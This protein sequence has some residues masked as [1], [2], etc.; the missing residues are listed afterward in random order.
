MPPSRSPFLPAPLLL[1]LS[2]LAFAPMT[3]AQALAPQLRLSEADIDRAG[4]AVTA[5]LATLAGT[6]GNGARFAG[7]VI[8]APASQRI[9][10]SELAGVVQAL[11]VS[12]LQQVQAG[13]PMVTLFSQPYL[14]L[15]GQYVH[16]ATQA[17]LAADKLARDESLFGDGII[18]RARLDESR[19]AAR[20]SALAAAEHSQALR[21]AGLSPRQVG[22]L[23]QAG[24]LSPL[25][26]VRAPAAGT[27]L[28][29]PVQPGQQVDAGAIIARLGQAAPLWVE[30]QAARAQPHLKVGDRLQVANC[31]MLRVI[32][33]SPVVNSASQALQVR[34]Q[35]LDRDPCLKI[36]AYVEASLLAPERRAG[37]VAVPEAALVRQGSAQFIFV[38]APGGF[39]VVPVQASAAGGGMVWVHG[40]VA[41]GDAVAS[42]GLVALKGAWSGLG[43]P[44]AAAPGAAGAR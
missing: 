5:A 7:T 25:L 6:E 1:A 17:R 19:A 38:R 28:E 4:I 10:S 11:H 22:A 21:R 40:A 27:V 14:A 20:L 16:S 26:V 8:A 29:L 34:A 24:S 2:A 39:R 15:Q 44:A 12:S 43:K 3:M 32:A 13:T 42:K 35:Q 9:A 33:I 41:A 23:A 37:S 30:L 31:S 18:A 36:N